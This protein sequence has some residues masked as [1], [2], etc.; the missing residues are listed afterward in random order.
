MFSDGVD[1]EPLAA[2]MLLLLCF[3]ESPRPG[4]TCPQ[5]RAL[6]SSRAAQR[7]KLPYVLLLELMSRRFRIWHVWIYQSRF[8]S[9]AVLPSYI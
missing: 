5:Q 4:T 2:C 8:W 3:S 1:P 7:H 6:Q 9:A